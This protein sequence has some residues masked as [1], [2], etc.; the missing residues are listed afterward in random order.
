[1]GEVDK[2]MYS[3]N[4]LHHMLEGERFWSEEGE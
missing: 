3:I 1:M 4:E 2:G